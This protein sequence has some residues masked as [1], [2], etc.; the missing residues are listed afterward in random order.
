[1]SNAAPSSQRTS[2]YHMTRSVRRRARWRSLL[3]R[4][5]AA[6]VAT[7]CTSYQPLHREDPVTSAQPVAVRF[8]SP[9][10]VRVVLVRGDSGELGSVSEVRGRVVA[11]AGDSMTMRVDV[12]GGSITA[13]GASSDDAYG[14]R[15]ARFAYDA[16]VRV[17][18][19][20]LSVTHSLFLALLV[21][22]ALAALFLSYANSELGEP[23]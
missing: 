23:Y 1:M 10:T 19:D 12:R 9:R 4:C 17:F 7:A 16:D 8:A 2:G 15:L 5:G 18:E 3:V 22:A 13:A 20:R 21:A 14:V 11:F 6:L